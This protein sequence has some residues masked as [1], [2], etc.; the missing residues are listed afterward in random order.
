MLLWHYLAVSIF[1]GTDSAFADPH[2]IETADTDLATPGCLDT[3]VGC[4]TPNV[5]TVGVGHVITMTNT[6]EYGIHTFTSGTV[7]GFTARPDTEFDSGILSFG[8][9]F[10]FISDIPDVY[11]YYCSLHTWMQGT[12]IVQGLSLTVIQSITGDTITIRGQTDRVSE[13]ITVTVTAPNGNVVSILQVSLTS[14]TEITPTMSTGYF[15]D[16]ITITRPLWSQEG[17]YKIT[18]HQNDDPKYNASTGVYIYPPTISISSDKSTY[19]ENEMMKVW[20]NISQK[21]LDE[22]LSI[23]L[24]DPNGESIGSTQVTAYSLM[25]GENDRYTTFFP[26]DRELD[27]GKW[28]VGGVYTIVGE[29][30]GV[31]DTLAVNVITS[32]TN[33]IPPTI[34]ISVNPNS[35]EQGD[36]IVVTGKVTNTESDVTFVVKSPSGN[37]IVAIAQVSPD[38][39]GN[40]SVFIEVTST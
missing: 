2:N 7:D 16:T 13:G 32:Q 40:Y 21:I 22:N 39:Y 1:F 24:Y 12:I 31:K 25:V 36:T 3:A 30:A 23:T 10:G 5:L 17:F 29:Y 6:D 19:Q 37:N 38:Y 14:I 26:Y 11:P 9:S 18:A 27:D 35:V 4:Y 28:Y 33:P 15:T 34:S 8:E 20:Y